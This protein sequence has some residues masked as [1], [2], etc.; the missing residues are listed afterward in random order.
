MKFEAARVSGG[1]TVQDLW[2]RYLAVG[3]HAD[4]FDIDAHLH[5]VA[6][7]S[8]FEGDVLAHALNERLAEVYRASCIPF[9]LP[10]PDADSADTPS[11]V[12]GLLDS[13]LTPDAVDTPAEHGDRADPAG[14]PGPE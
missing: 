11:V 4:L 6:P 1:L 14:A 9:R 10:G 8:T 12:A 3:G 13:F 7:L 5:G 2:L